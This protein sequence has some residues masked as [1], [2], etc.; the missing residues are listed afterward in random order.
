[1]KTTTICAVAILA[2][3]LFGCAAD[4]PS[5]DAGGS[6]SGTTDTVPGD[7]A[8][9]SAVVDSGTTDTGTDVPVGED[10]VEPDAKVVD[11][12]P[13]DTGSDVPVVEDTAVPDAAVV[14]AGTQD[15]GTQD[16]GTPDA[17]EEDVAVADAVVNDAAAADAP[18]PDDSG[19]IPLDAGN[20]SPTFK[21]DAQPI[22]QKYCGDCHNGG[23]SGGHDIAMD[24]DDAL[25]ASYYCNDLNKG[26]CTVVRIEDGSMPKGAGP[27]VSA[28]DLE[29]LKKWIDG[30]M[31][32]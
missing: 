3:G 8:K 9:D 11:G 13:A 15:A 5:N 16:A 31:Q 27:K 18:S 19:P 24:Y 32:P 10:T 29:V 20:A 2:L 12:G 28:D 4:T 26:E 22:F 23:G 17:V 14:D 25:L 6:D 1:M 30:G 7:T 21:G